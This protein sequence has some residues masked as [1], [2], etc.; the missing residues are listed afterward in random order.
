ML[1][2]MTERAGCGP[3]RVST[4]TGFALLGVLWIIVGLSVVA[5]AMGRMS[6]HAIMAAQTQH[7][8]I[9][10]RWLADGCLA[11]FRSVTNGLLGAEAARATTIWRTLDRTLLVDSGAAL[12]ECDISMQTAGRIVLNRAVTS[13]LD[14]LPGMTLEAIAHILQFQQAGTPITDLVLVESALTRPAKLLFDTH[15]RDLLIETTP[16]PD[17]W[18]VRARAHVG[19]PPTPVNIEMRLV[20]AGARAAVV[21]WVEW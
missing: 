17:V 2:R 20:R 7:G 9:V 1:Q 12:T 8:R 3:R 11:R 5:L 4:S 18:V 13:D 21:R 10:G 6:W 16:E 14:T 19:V 15:Y